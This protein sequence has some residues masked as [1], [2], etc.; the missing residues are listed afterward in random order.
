MLDL[1]ERLSREPHWLRPTTAGRNSSGR[2]FGLGWARNSL[3]VL[4]GLVL[5]AQ[6]IEFKTS[7]PAAMTPQTSSRGNVRIGLR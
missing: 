5:L 6:P 1:C 3:T 2:Y 7:S 4:G